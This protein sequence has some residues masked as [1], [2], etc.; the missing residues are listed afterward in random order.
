MA[1]TARLRRRAAMVMVKEL[2]VGVRLRPE[3]AGRMIPEATALMQ[4]EVAALM[5]PAAEEKVRAARAPVPTRPE[6]G[7]ARAAPTRRG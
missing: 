5:R 2:V 1:R 3:A 7:A 6:A 4:P